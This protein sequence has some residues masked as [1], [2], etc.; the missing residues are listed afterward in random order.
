M[1][2]SIRATSMLKSPKLLPMTRPIAL[3]SVGLAIA[4]CASAQ[5]SA[6]AVTAPEAAPTEVATEGE[7]EPSAEEVQRTAPHAPDPDKDRFHVTALRLWYYRD[8]LPKS[9]DSDVLGVELNSAWGWKGFD[10]MNISYFEVADY[11]RPVPGKPAGNA[12]PGFEAATGITDL[13]SAT[14]LSRQREH[15]SPHHF[16]YGAAFQFPTASSEVLGSGKWSAGPAVEYEYH[17]GRF[18]A[19]FV[20]LQLW[21]FAGD[22]D[23]KSVNMLMIKPMVTYDLAKRWKLV[24]MPYGISVYWNKSASDAVYLPVGGGL[25]YNFGLFSQELAVSAQFFKYVIRPSAGSEYDLRFMLE[26]D[27]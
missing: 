22:A 10:F 14:L 8:F 25:Q 2:G 1:L 3:L 11:P 27:F 26:L 17:K 4:V 7:A 16:A 5:E 13:L 18:Y 24:Y 12:E 23:R 19:A 15:H 9:D 6:Q 20:A 21:S